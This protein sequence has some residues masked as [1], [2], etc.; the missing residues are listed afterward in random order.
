M[1]A[2]RRPNSRSTSLA[3]GAELPL[4]VVDGREILGEQLE[5]GAG[6]LRLLV[7]QARRDAERVGRA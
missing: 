7:E 3:V 6:D 4:D 1:S 5:A 2:R